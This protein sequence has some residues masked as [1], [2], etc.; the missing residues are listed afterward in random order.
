MYFNL[1][2]YVNEAFLWPPLPSDGSSQLISNVKRRKNWTLNAL[3][4]ECYHFW[5]NIVIKEQVLL[6]PNLGV[7]KPQTLFL[8]PLSGITE[9]R[10]NIS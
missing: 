10:R 8:D 2:V 1:Q 5:A 6:P 9:L 4:T 3:R 7:C